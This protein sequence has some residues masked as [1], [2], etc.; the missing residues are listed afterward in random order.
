[1]AYTGAF[2]LKRSKSNWIYTEFVRWL[3]VL[4]VTCIGAD[5]HRAVLGSASKRIT[6][7][8]A[9]PYEE[10]D[11][12]HEFA[13][14]F[15]RKSIK[16]AATKAAIFDASMHQVVYRLGLRPIPHCQGGIIHE[17]GEAEASGPGPG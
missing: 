14:L 12:R 7:H 5:F 3:T 15:S 2:N 10:L 9:P 16:T 11:L 1:M 8:R 13:H 4:V 17:A 6:P